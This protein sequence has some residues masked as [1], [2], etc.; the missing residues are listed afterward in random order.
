MRRLNLVILLASLHLCSARTPSFSIHDD[1]L[2][3][4]QFDVVFTDG[5]ISEH[6][7][8]A[9][10]EDRARHPTYSAD[11]PQPTYADGSTASDTPA[12]YSYELMSLERHRY[13]CSIP[14]IEP[15]LPENQTAHELAKAEEARELG[16]AAAKGWQLLPQ[17]EDSCL[18]FMSGWWSYSFCNNREIVQFHALA[19]TPNGLPPRRDP[20]TAEF[21][22]GRNPAISA[23]AAGKTRQDS[24]DGA[25]APLPAELQVKGDQ[26][27]LVQRLEGGT[28]CD[29]TGRER[30]VEVQYHCAPGLTKD[31]IGW[32]KEVTICAYVMVVNTPRLCDDVAFLPPEETRANLISCRIIANG[33]PPLLD[34]GALASAATSPPTTP[35]AA[36]ES[37]EADKASEVT[38]GGVVIGARK[39]LS[40]AD[41]V[42]K[43]PVR[44]APPRG[45]WSGGDAGDES[46]LVEVLVRAASK[47]EGGKIKMPSAEE[48]ERIDIDP[49]VV[50]EM[51]EKMVQMAGDAGW[52]LEI[53]QINGGDLREL[54]GTIDGDEANDGKDKNDKVGHDKEHDGSEEKFF[55]EEL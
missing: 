47:G 52:Q 44:L 6:D 28:V 34:Q 43:P 49:Q 39:V 53:V 14:I 16:R 11:F 7:A 40:G 12:T 48:L 3:F 4:P 42:G 31:R 10:L 18:Y 20:H 8:Q 13:I 24:G 41:E 37:T 9:L 5:S 55:K 38:V 15:S 29:L 1:L 30:T 51:K 2:A 25:S 26:R 21:I 32:I 50:E 36:S 27:Y 17:L 23:S 19:A 22:L 33:A 46:N 54:R 35:S 45:F